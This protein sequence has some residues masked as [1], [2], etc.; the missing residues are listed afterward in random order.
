M[1]VRL[2]PRGVVVVV[3]VAVACAVWALVMALGRG[4]RRG[5][6]WR[7]ERLIR[8]SSLPTQWSKYPYYCSVQRV[9]RALGISVGGHYGGGIVINPR[10]V[11]TAAHVARNKSP[12]DLWV[13][14][15][16]GLRKTFVESVHVHPNYVDG[17]AGYDVALLKLATSVT[18]PP[19]A[20]ADN[21]VP[22]GH[23][24]TIVGRGK[25]R[26]DETVDTFKS[27]IH[28][29]VMTKTLMPTPTPTPANNTITLRSIAATADRTTST[30]N[31][32]SGGPI[33]AHTSKGPRLV[34]LV[35][36][37]MRGCT[38]YQTPDG[39]YAMDTYG[40]DLVTLR[41]WITQVMAQD[42]WCQKSYG[43]TTKWSAAKKAC[44]RGVTR[45]VSGRGGPV[46]RT[47]SQTCTMRKGCVDDKL[48]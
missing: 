44:V 35:S 48:A 27:S 38:P 6:R 2:S 23:A 28:E 16:P 34:S 13:L 30:C 8:P 12:I 25:T 29:T 24:V 40:P 33:V 18:S 41:P 14:T 1:K 11:L 21:R 15:Y 39:K 26:P 47:F 9:V 7:V 4:G 32:D 43:P 42:V 22:D 31:A 45:T 36:L 10:Y 19:I 3:V 20:V 46:Q 37:G 5:G 17:Q